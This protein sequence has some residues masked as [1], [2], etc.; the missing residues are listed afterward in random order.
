M[1][2]KAMMEAGV[3]DKQKCIFVDDS[4]GICLSVDGPGLIIVNVIGAKEY[5]MEGSMPFII[6]GGSYSKSGERD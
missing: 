2:Q 3:R 4:L 1:F 5:R 6:S